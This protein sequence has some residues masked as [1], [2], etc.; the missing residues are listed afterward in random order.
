[1]GKSSSDSDAPEQ[2]N[3]SSRSPWRTK[4]PHE[5]GPPRMTQAEIDLILGENEN[6]HTSGFECLR[7]SVCCCLSKSDAGRASCQHRYQAWCGCSSIIAAEAAEQTW[8]EVRSAPLMTCLG[9]C[10]VFLVV[11]V[12]AVLQTLLARAPLIFLRL[13]ENAEG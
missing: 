2:L 7:Q 6:G 4:L 10:T 8:R 3:S 11:V 13:A 1:M 9:A 12:A 5:V